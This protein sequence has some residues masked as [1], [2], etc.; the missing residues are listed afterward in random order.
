[1]YAGV[2][3]ALAVIGAVVVGNFRQ[4]A[5][6]PGVLA[7]PAGPSVPV[8]AT[9]GRQ[10]RHVYS[11]VVRMEG[12]RGS[13]N[14]NLLFACPASVKCPRAEGTQTWNADARL[15]PT[16]ASCAHSQAASASRDNSKCQKNLTST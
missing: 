16:W 11:R 10:R 1:M 14:V 7:S 3:F 2:V 15:E 6:S 12:A 4:P 8:G 5:Q 13:F 9:E